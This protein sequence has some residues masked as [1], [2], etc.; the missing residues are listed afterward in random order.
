MTVTDEQDEQK[1]P[2]D[3]AS[4]MQEAA[5]LILMLEHHPAGEIRLSW[6]LWTIFWWLF[7][8]YASKWSI[9]MTVFE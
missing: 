6:C 4:E 8:E 2:Q 9:W 3:E 5:K 1:G 7:L